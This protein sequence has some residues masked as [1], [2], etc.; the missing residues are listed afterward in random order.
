[1]HECQLEDATKGKSGEIRPGSVKFC[2]CGSSWCP[3][4][5]QLYSFETVTRSGVQNP[6]AVSLSR[7][8]AASPAQLAFTSTLPYT[9]SLPYPFAFAY[10]SLRG[11]V[12]VGKEKKVKHQS[13]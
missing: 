10:R 6:G 13:M 3:Q 1:M 5:G 4:F 7:C 11:R 2:D 12:F 8:V 9:L